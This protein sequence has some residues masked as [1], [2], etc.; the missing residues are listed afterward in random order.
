MMAARG[1]PEQN[2]LLVEHGRADGDVRQM[3]PAVVGRVDRIN[4]ARTNLA[5]VLADD[6]LHRAIH[7]A[8]MDRHV[9]RIGDQ[10]AIAVNTAPRNRALPLFLGNRPPFCSTA[11][12]PAI[13]ERFARGAFAISIGTWVG[14]LRGNAAAP[15]RGAATIG[16]FAVDFGLP[17]V[18]TTTTSGALND[19][20]LITTT[21]GGRE[22]GINAYGQP[23]PPPL[24][25]R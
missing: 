23:A 22:H 7:R 21:S 2:L 4:V 8:E 13:D 16:F 18:S 15:D 24:P 19:G 6:G 9:R 17:A 10:R 5:F 1:D 14:K 12:L 25:L 20:G 3:R 11:A